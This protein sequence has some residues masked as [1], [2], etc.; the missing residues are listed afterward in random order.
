MG[1]LADAAATKPD[2]SWIEISTDTTTWQ[3]FTLAPITVGR[4]AGCTVV[5]TDQRA[6]RVQGV[7]RRDGRG[8]VYE[9]QLS[10]NGSWVGGG[11][12]Q[13]ADV[14]PDFV[15]SVGDGTDA[16][17]VRAR[18]GQGGDRGQ[19]TAQD[20]PARARPTPTLDIGRSSENHVV[21]DD[22]MVS[23]RHAQFVPASDTGPAHVVDLGS[24]N[25]V[26]I[27]GRRV[28]GSADLAQGQQLRIGPV[29]FELADGHLRRRVP[30][31]VILDAR[32]VTVITPDGVRR[33]DA[34]DL[35]V[36]RG[37]LICVVGPSGAGK[38]TLLGVLTGTREKAAGTITLAGLSLD[39]H[40]DDIRQQI[41]YVPQDDIIHHQLTPRQELR[42]AAELRLEPDVDPAE[43]AEL[44]D[45]VLTTVG[46]TAPADRPISTLSGGQRKRANV[47][48]E[49]IT[50][51]PVMFFDEPT[52]GLDPGH[53]KLLMQQL[54]V[55]ADDGRAVVVVTHNIAYINL[56]DYVL[57]LAPGGRPAF[58]GPP[59]TALQAFERD[60]FA[61]VFIGLEDGRLNLV[62]VA[63]GAEP[64]SSAATPPP[65]AVRT[66]HSW[67]QRFQVLARRYLTI[68]AADRRNLALL[69]VQAPVLGLLAR[70]IGSGA[71]L[72][73]HA[74]GPNP[75]A[76]RVLF[77]LV[78]CATWI[79]A[80]NS[81]REVVKERPT[82]LRERLIDVP[83][84]A[85][86]ASKLA[87]LG[88]LTLLQSAV[89]VVVVL[90]GRPGPT[91]ITG[92]G[93]A[94][95]IG[96]VWLAGVAGLCLGLLI[97]A[98]VTKPD[99]AMALL[100][101]LLIPQFVLSG[102]VLPLDQSPPLQPLSWLTS[103]RWGFAAAASSVDL[104]ALENAP[105]PHGA[106]TATTDLLWH[107]TT[108]VWTLDCSLLLIMSAAALAGAA[109]LLR[110]SEG[111]SRWSS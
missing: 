78:L 7:F 67:A 4:D 68:L 16:P 32:G 90:A 72:G 108:R 95:L 71:G 24:A 70:L 99:K 36:R 28:D 38:S 63:P 100:P 79:G 33:L 9:D 87:V 34:V 44:V 41:G 43:R 82:Y 85:Y 5:I 101:L 20:G 14:G 94:E 51:P 35:Q 26:F 50:K 19:P 2:A 47:A 105:A 88:A 46:L 18:V 92:L 10:A 54:R 77:T 12:T 21:V 83:I 86:L 75:T 66:A 93:A 106:A 98:A 103:S 30:D 64:T 89:M 48:I 8:W 39:E 29:T 13:Q 61:D 31:P 53:D 17:R 15:I 11:R 91:S 57:V 110:R 3:R 69:L 96:D 109:W 74:A 23:R 1:A 60:D 42:Y 56:C 65:P 27:D 22:L 81:V 73:L 62:S 59:T 58:W 37:E 111:G 40:Y 6:S 84:S 49:L 76:R 97:S 102:A 80:S 52:S 55:L 104:H 25:G 45:T 107:H